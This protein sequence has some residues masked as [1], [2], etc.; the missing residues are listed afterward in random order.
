MGGRGNSGSTGRNSARVEGMKE[1][2]GD[3]T[4]E[5]AINDDL[6]YHL[7]SNETY[8]TVDKFTI[9]STPEEVE[10]SGGRADVK[11]EYTVSLRI[12]Y[13][14]TDS[15]GFTQTMYETATESRTANYSVNVFKGDS[16]AK[17]AT[18]QR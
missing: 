17:R 5:D 2:V 1:Y 9:L 3:S 11:V 6:R 8:A 4:I 10:S 18:R 15:D 16:D 14:E 7:G 12:P 13:Q